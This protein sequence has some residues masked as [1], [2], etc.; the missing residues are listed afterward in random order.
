[1]AEWAVLSRKEELLKRTTRDAPG[2]KKNDTLIIRQTGKVSCCSIGFTGK[3]F[4]FDVKTQPRSQALSPLSPDPG[5]G[6]RS[7]DH[8]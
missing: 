3:I 8:L 2:F 7:C 5:C 1:M 6:S 4:G